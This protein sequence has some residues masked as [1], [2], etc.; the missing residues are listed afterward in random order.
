[1]KAVFRTDAS[2]EIGTG[3]VI[4]CLTLADALSQRGIQCTFICREHPGH[5]NNYIRSCGY[6]VRALSFTENIK[7]VENKSK[8]QRADYEN[9][10]GA[11]WKVDANDSLSSIAGEHVE[12][13]FVDHYALDCKWENDL[14]SICGKLI[15]ID[16]L[17]DRHHEC[18]I[19]LDQNLGRYTDDY[20]I[21]VPY[22]C[23]I[24]VGPRHAIL[25]P[26]FFRMREESLSRRKKY[27][28]KRILI[29]MGGVDQ[30]DMTSKVLRALSE[31]QLPE[32]CNITV[33]LGATAPYLNNVQN[34][35]KKMPY[36]TTLEVD[37][38]N[39]AQLMAESDLSIGA[40]GTTSWERAC[41][42]LPAMLI[43]LAENQRLI[44]ESLQDCGAALI[45]EDS[46]SLRS[47]L[48]LGIEKLSEASALKKMS[49]AACQLTDGLGVD[50][51]ING[52]L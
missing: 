10:L 4:R 41:L 30:F 17:A 2:I 37:V 12:Y 3:H 48:Q 1:M 16:D 38:S 43:I 5:L 50:R 45:I 32:R 23:S 49:E 20:R 7:K 14:R 29:A 13:L 27:K 39:M 28:L 46:D 42:G 31:C 21:L 9:W 25:R 52:L 33:I 35:V 18:D 8:S 34:E 6:E 36:P 15:V 24:L 11:G 22:D 19:L 44:A 51:F 26:E 47:S 40:P